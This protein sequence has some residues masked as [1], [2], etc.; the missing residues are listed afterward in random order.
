MTMKINVNLKA[1]GIFQSGH[2]KATSPIAY[3]WALEKR[4]NFV[5][6]PSGDRPKNRPIAFIQSD[7]TRRFLFIAF[8]SDRTSGHKGKQTNNRF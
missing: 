2:K 3:F 6:T 5:W 8:K 4:K 7:R 1:I